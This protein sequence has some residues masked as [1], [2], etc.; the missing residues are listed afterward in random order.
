MAPA[1]E[2]EFLFGRPPLAGAN[3]CFHCWECQLPS[4]ES[5]HWDMGVDCRPKLETGVKKRTKK[6]GDVI[7]LCLPVN[8]AKKVCYDLFDG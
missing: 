8:I 6:H 1:F 5:Y 2:Y 3:C 7:N 4:A